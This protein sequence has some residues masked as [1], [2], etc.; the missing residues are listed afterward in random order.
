MPDWLEVM[1][2][3]P[4]KGRNVFTWLDSWVPK[5][6]FTFRGGAMT[7]T[8]LKDHETARTKQLGQGL[9]DPRP[10]FTFHGDRLDL[11]AVRS[12]LEKE[13]G[14]LVAEGLYPDDDV[15]TLDQE[16]MEKW[17]SV[18]GGRVGSY[19]FAESSILFTGMT[20]HQESGTP[21]PWDVFWDAWRT[22]ME[23]QFPGAL[24]S[25]PLKPKHL[26]NSVGYGQ[27]I[28]IQNRDGAAGYPYTNMEADQIREAL[29]RPKFQGRP[30]KGIVFNHAFKQLV[31]WLKEDMPMEG[32]LYEAVAQPA[33]LTFRG[34]RAVD[35]NLRVLG[36]RV[37]GRN[38]TKRQINWRPLCQ[39]VV[40]LSCQRFSY[41]VSRFGLNPLVTTS[42][43]LQLPD[44][45]GSTPGIPLTV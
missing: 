30:T 40:S 22:Q 35:Y 6:G 23:L 15:K 43:T 18:M 10:A 25:P 44:S 3:H 19:V 16:S 17:N 5:A 14:R 26:F 2:K 33:T 9:N 31:A 21:I 39:G 36:T 24:D 13:Q 45:T 12:A 37:P 27:G 20:P 41:S 11:Q 7:L 29:D 34:D 4:F 42:L 32:P 8:R 38:S 28:R 1:Q